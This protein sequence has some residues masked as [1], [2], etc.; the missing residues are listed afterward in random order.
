MAGPRILVVDDNVELLTLLSSSFEEAGYAVHTAARGRAALELARKEKPDLVV[1]DVLLPDLMGYDVAEG[2]K[3]LRIPFIFMSGVQ[4]GGKSAANA[5]G[6]YGALAYFE[7]P[8]ERRALLHEVRKRLP[9]IPPPPQFTAFDV[10]AAPQVSETEPEIPL[11]NRVPVVGAAGRTTLKGAGPIQLKPVD[12]DL[13]ERLSSHEQTSPQ[14][15]ASRNVVEV[16]PIEEP[17]R[18]VPVPAEDLRPLETE[19]VRRGELKDNLP[20]LLAAFYAAKETGELG[21]S[22]GQVKKVVY[23]E[24][25]MPGFALS[26]L[27]ADRPGPF[28]ARAREIAEGTRK[29][30]PADAPATRPPAGGGLLPMGAPGG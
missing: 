19:G 16:P 4:K 6:K 25:G 3:R 7:K 10:E 11:T 8:F 2:L 14:R 18:A 24:A 9:V 22:K 13:A 30:A 5:T 21:L 1:L 20:Q 26:N 23:F 28:L 15:V 12:P 29:H 17:P 27:V